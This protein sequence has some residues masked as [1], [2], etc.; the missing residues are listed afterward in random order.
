MLYS[1]LCIKDKWPFCSHPHRLRARCFVIK[2][3]F[4]YELCIPEGK[5]AAK[6]CI[7]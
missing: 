3:Y 2:S 7:K 1:T 6:V 5:N 4:Q